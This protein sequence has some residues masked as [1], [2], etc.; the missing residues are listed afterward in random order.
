MKFTI[1]KNLILALFIIS[2]V[3]GLLSTFLANTIL[4]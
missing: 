3:L 1:D 2:A 4:A